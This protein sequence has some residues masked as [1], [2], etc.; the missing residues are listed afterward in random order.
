MKCPSVVPRV[1]SELGPVW[2]DHVLPA[3]NAVLGKETDHQ[4]K[5]LFNTR[6]IGWF[7]TPKLFFNAMN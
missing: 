7:I 5:K 2:N 6:K 1:W 3:E 4:M